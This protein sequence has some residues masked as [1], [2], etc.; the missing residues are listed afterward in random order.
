[1]AQSRIDN[2]QLLTKTGYTYSDKFQKFI[3]SNYPGQ[4]KAIAIC[5]ELIFYGVFIYFYY[6]GPVEDTIKTF[7]LCKFIAIIL[8]TRYMF[9][10]LTTIKCQE[11]QT[12][13]FQLNSK[14]AIVTTFILFLAHSGPKS[15]STLL[16]V[17]AYAL[18]SSAARYGYTVDNLITVMLVYL[19]F[20]ANI[21]N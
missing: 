13:Y 19:L 16:M 1:M 4:E 2:S 14:V 5:N 8:F 9:S 10:Y 6:L 20:T 21:L 17:V 11:K 18:L 7:L 15:I 12:S 3:S